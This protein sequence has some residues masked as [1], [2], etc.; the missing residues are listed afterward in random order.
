MIALALALLAFL[1]PAAAAPAAPSPLRLYYSASL[2]GN[3]DGCT[4]EY[5]PTAGL[6]KRAAFLRALPAE[7]RGLLLDAGDLTG[8]WPD[9]ELAGELVAAYREL[10]YTAAAVGEQ[11]LA[12]GAA[13]LRR[14]AK[15]FPLLGHNLEV[16]ERGRWRPF[17]GRPLRVESGGRRLAVFALLE[18]GLPHVL[19]EETRRDFRLEPP[20]RAA[21]R[22]LRQAAEGGAGLTVLLYHGSEEGLRR[23]LA[24]VEGIDLAVLGHEGRLID[25]VRVG[26]TLVVSPGEQGDRLGL[27]EVP[28]ADGAGLA[29]RRGRQPL[30][31][32]LL[33]HRPG[34]PRAA[35]A[36]RAVQRAPPGPPQEGGRGVG[37][38]A[39][40]IRYSVSLRAS[41]CPARHSSAGRP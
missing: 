34:R 7:A 27:L 4:C 8:V 20:E 36:D 40:T 14:L 17:S 29:A 25:A 32:L 5:N 41:Q 21:P 16:R 38:G 12:L 10:G 33:P 24:A 39:P 2:S 23:L 37:G 26:S 30:P 19:T 31:P 15:G 11:E 9:E 28:A 3:L 35:A 6:V 18:P 22:L 13:A 1:G